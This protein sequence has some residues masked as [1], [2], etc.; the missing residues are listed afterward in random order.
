MGSESAQ[1][2][3]QSIEQQLQAQNGFEKAAAQYEALSEDGVFIY[4]TGYEELFGKEGVRRDLLNMT[5][6]ILAVCLIF[7]GIHSKEYETNVISLI[8]A[9]G[10]EKEIQRY[11]LRYMLAICLMITLIFSLPQYIRTA[12]IYSLPHLPESCSNLMIL[13]R[14]PSFISIGMLV[15]MIIAL[16]Y[17]IIILSG[18]AVN[19][20]SMRVKDSTAV[21][22]FS[23]L[24]LA[25]PFLIVRMLI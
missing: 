3:A 8:R 10:K 4:S 15:I 12:G 11:K 22:I 6:V 19:A 7:A 9:Y 17:L 21:L 5:A 1:I 25:V 13:S 2:I 23:S 18:F 16:R 24:V 20:L 14:I